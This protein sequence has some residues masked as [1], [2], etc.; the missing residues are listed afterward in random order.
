MLEKFCRKEVEKQ[1]DKA[2]RIAG[3]KQ[4]KELK[5]REKKMKRLEDERSLEMYVLCGENMRKLAEAKLHELEQMDDVSQASQDLLEQV[6]GIDV[7]DVTRN[8][9]VKQ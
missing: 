9:R 7:D 3:Q 1:N 5:G 2:L 4:E 6:S 8:Y